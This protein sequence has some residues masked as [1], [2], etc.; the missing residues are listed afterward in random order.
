MNDFF[1]YFCPNEH[2]G[3]RHNLFSVLSKFQVI[4]LWKASSD[5]L[6]RR[7]I[8]NL[9]DQ[10]PLWSTTFVIH[11]PIFWMAGNNINIIMQL[12][13][14]EW[15]L[16][17]LKSTVEADWP[18][19][20]CLA[21]RSL[22]VMLSPHQWSMPCPILSPSTPPLPSPS[23]PPVSDAKWAERPNTSRDRRE[24]A[25]WQEKTRS[26]WFFHQSTKN[27]IISFFG[28]F[29]LSQNRKHA[30]CKN[31]KTQVSLSQYFW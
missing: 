5:S 1:R 23:P 9:Y 21:G 14:R 10:Q 30:T 3:K 28:P 7:W 22:A 18:L 12:R 17:W 27:D 6:E 11:R 13:Q 15:E 29:I 26:L 20:H 4:C 31:A 24:I 2:T 25:G 8:D 16:S 19:G